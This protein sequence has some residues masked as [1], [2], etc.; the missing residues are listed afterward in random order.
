MRDNKEHGKGTGF[1]KGMTIHPTGNNGEKRILNEPMISADHP[2]FFR[3]TAKDPRTAEPP[4]G[5]DGLTG[6]WSG[7]W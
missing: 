7:K 1:P 3:T 5:T 4:L 6:K 2:G